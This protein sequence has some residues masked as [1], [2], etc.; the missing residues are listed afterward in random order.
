VAVVNLPRCHVCA[1]EV[2]RMTT[3]YDDFMRRLRVRV[4]CHGE[5]QYVDIP[6]DVLERVVELSFRGMAFSDEARRLSS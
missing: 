1:K 3:E 4:F 5:T 6:R 2:D